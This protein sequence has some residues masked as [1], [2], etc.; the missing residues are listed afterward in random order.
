MCLIVS[1]EE[2]KQH[3]RVDTSDDDSYIQMLINAA[4]QFITNTTG[5]TF[6]ST[7]ALAKTVCLLLIGDLYEKR[8]I[9]T[10]KASEK[11]RDIVTMI[12]TQLSLSGDS[13]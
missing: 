4:E 7:N 2:A 11:I 9:T 13:T 12:L 5:K 1:L 6:D 10:D 3:L 8:E